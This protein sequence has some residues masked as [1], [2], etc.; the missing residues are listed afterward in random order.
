MLCSSTKVPFTVD[1]SQT[2]IFFSTGVEKVLC[3]AS[4]VLFIIY[5]SQ[6]ISAFVAQPSELRGKK[7]RGKTPWNASCDRDE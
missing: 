1:Q 2:N 5:Q 7:F 6:N 3:S 4:T